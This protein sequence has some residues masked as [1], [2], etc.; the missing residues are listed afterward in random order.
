MSCKSKA[1]SEKLNKP[2]VA[3]IRT[4]KWQKS[5]RDMQAKLDLQGTASLLEATPSGFKAL[6]MSRTPR[7]QALIRCAHQALAHSFTCDV[8]QDIA[9]APWASHSVRSM[10]TSTDLYWG[11]SPAQGRAV[12]A[13]EHW[14]RLKLV[15]QQGVS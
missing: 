5:T 13:R 12:L 2:G 15:A 1:L 11:H 6:G 7:V 10:T 8:S 4:A 3:M 9:R 14:L